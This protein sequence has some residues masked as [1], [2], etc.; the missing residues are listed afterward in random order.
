MSTT[1]R[2]GDRHSPLTSLSFELVGMIREVD[3]RISSGP[4]AIRAALDGRTHDRTQL[5]CTSFLFS[6][7]PQG[8]STHDSLQSARDFK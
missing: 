6:L 5:G 1:G 2:T 8:P 3:L 4:A 7:A